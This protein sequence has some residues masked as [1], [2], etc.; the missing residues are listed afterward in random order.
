MKK[1]IA[2]IV[3]TSFL[4]CSPKLFK[5][6]WTKEEAPAYFK[7]R[8]ETTKGNF[9]IE[10]KRAWSP[11][12]VDRLYQLIKNEFYT[13]IAIF[14]VVPGF[15]A[16]FGIHNNSLLNSSWRKFKIEDEKVVESNDLMTVSFARGG[17]K[18][19]TT[20]IFINLKNNKRLDVIASSGVKGFPVIAKVVAGKDN[21]LKFYDA[22]GDKL[23][24]RQDSINKY[25]N[26]FIR[27]KYPKVDFIKKAYILK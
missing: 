14:R 17:A 5:E 13:D 22:Y 11:K 4:S 8:F 18:T 16:Q 2:F 12:A 6:K 21:V 26:K 25:G 20:Q 19:R 27:A 15:V 24:A 9:E 10:A 3:L 7:A 23:G 1:I